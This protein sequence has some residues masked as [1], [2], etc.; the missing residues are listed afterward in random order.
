[1]KKCLRISLTQLR[2]EIGNDQLM[3]GS[4]RR[5]KGVFGTSCAGIT[6]ISKHLE[7]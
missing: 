1:M 5:S 3:E 6:V 2:L 7:N 4:V